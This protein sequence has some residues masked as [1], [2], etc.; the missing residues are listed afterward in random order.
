M[1]A[2]SIIAFDVGGANIKTVASDGVA[3]SL[4]FPLWK[5]PERLAGALRELLSTAPDDAIVVAT[6]TGELADCFPTKQQGVSHIVSALKSAVGSRVLR[7]Y[8]TDG[9]F[10]SPT[11]AQAAYRLAAASN[12]HALATFIGTHDAWRDSLLIDIGST[13]CDVIPIVGGRVAATGKT[14]TQRLLAGELVYL[15]AERTSIACLVDALPY[16]AQLCP[17]ARELFATT[18]DVLLTLDRVQDQPNSFDTADGRPATRAFAI[19]RLGRCL[20]ADADEW[21]E[22]D[23]VMAA[24]HLAHRMA[25]FVYDA[26][27]RVYASQP[28]LRGAPIVVAGHGETLLEPLFDGRIAQHQIE[29]LRDH[30]G[31]PASRAAPAFAMVRLA[32]RML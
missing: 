26:I 13:T 29:L 16:R 21:T 19:A 11:I 30:I 25:G 2:Q 1:N 24:R 10:V 14:D 31:S 15:G 6:M 23:A 4:G 20:C 12:W 5:Q 8:L 3:H 17:I 18:L 32:E 7:V 27:S 9:R 28:A 22:A